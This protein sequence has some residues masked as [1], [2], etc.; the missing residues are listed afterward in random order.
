MIVD[1]EAI[2]NAVAAAVVAAESCG[3]SVQET[4]VPVSGGGGAREVFIYGTRPQR[5]TR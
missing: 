4:T 5:V 2:D 3:W 1:S